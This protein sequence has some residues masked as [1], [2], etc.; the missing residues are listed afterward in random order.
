MARTRAPE[1]RNLLA[2]ISAEHAIDGITSAEMVSI[3]KKDHASAIEN[4]G[5]DVLDIGLMKLA[6]SVCSRRSAAPS[7]QLEL[8]EEYGVPDLLTLTEHT[9]GGVCKIHK[10]IGS[11]TLT[12]VGDYIAEHRRPRARFSEKVK[13]LARLKTELS[14]FA[15]AE[16]STVNEC[17][18]AKVA[19]RKRA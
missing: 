17:W 11:M 16:T 4:E 7:V 14:E 2:A 8:F 9:A 15:E 18:A 19:K 10:A 6:A 5:Q 13:E 3:L 1:I 12:E